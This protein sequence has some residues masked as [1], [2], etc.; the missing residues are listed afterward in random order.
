[1]GHAEPN[2][3]S[4]IAAAMQ[5]A[6]VDDEVK[7]ASAE[8]TP[9]EETS[10]GA[11]TSETTE[12]ETEKTADVMDFA[13]QLDA[14]GDQFIKQ[15]SPQ[16]D[17]KGRVLAKLGAKGK[18]GTIAPTYKP[19]AETNLN[20]ILRGKEPKK[21]KAHS[22]IP[23]IPPMESVN[24]LQTNID[25]DATRHQMTPDNIMKT[26]EAYKVKMAGLR[27]RVLNKLAVQKVS[28]PR[29][30]ANPA[31]EAAPKQ[32]Q[33]GDRA[34]IGSNEAATKYTKG[35][36]KATIKS[37]L[38]GALDE[39]ALTKSTDSKLHE[40]LANTGKAGVKISQARDYLRKVASR[41]G[42]PEHARLIERLQQVREKTAAAKNMRSSIKEAMEKKAFFNGSQRVS[43]SQMAP[44][45]GA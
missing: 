36:A 15:A 3:K 11:T 24:K 28:A 13:E 32:P 4:L 34:L 43:S 8:T 38:R 22:Q 9:E 6:E 25:D 40:N 35:R 18:G 21:D 12:V 31:D 41:A 14:L 10:T 19:Q 42:T 7:T 16:A 2:L 30:A 45:T 5:E 17:L 33:Q 44:E 29:S 37:V 26:S 20:T 39:P 27:A 1:M 23:M